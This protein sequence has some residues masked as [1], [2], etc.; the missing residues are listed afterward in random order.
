MFIVVKFFTD[1][2]D[3]GHAYEVGDAYPRKGLEPTEGRILELSGDD[4]L[5]KTPL[6]KEVKDT[7]KKTTGRPRK[8]Q[9][10]TGGEKK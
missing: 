3:G 10:K 8:P 1:L 7:P 4:N 9:P 5:Q 2:Q 6:I